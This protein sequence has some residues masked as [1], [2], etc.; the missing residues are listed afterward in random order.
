MMTSAKC[1][2][3]NGAGR[4]RLTISPYQKPPELFTTH[5]SCAPA[6]NSDSAMNNQVRY[7]NPDGQNFPEVVRIKPPPLVSSFRGIAAV[8]SLRSRRGN[9]CVSEHFTLNK[10]RISCANRLMQFVMCVNHW[11]G[12]ADVSSE[13]RPG[14]RQAPVRGPIFIGVGEGN[15]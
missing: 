11:P 2:P 10:S 3:W 5:P 13:L 9:A 6:P 14:S 15:P 1:R 8:T 7:R 12:V 4:V